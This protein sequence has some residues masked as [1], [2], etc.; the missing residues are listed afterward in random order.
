MSS[1]YDLSRNLSPRT[2]N[3]NAMRS[4]KQIEASRINGAKSKGPITPQGKAISSR[5]GIREGLLART[6]VLA[7]ESEERFLALL[8]GYVQEFQPVIASEASLVEALTVAKWRQFRVWGVQKTGVDRDMAIQD[9]DFGPASVCAGFALRG[10]PDSICAPDLLHRYEVIY[11]RQ[12]A[13]LYTRLSDLKSKNKSTPRTPYIPTFPS[14]QTFRDTEST[15]PRSLEPRKSPCKSEPRNRLKTNPLKY[16]KHEN[17]PRTQGNPRANVGRPIVFCRLPCRQVHSAEEHRRLPCRQVH[18][19]G[20]LRHLPQSQFDRAMPP[21]HPDTMLTFD[22][23]PEDRRS[24]PRPKPSIPNPAQ[25]AEQSLSFKPDQRQRDL[26]LSTAKQGILN[27]SRQWGKSTVA[28]IKAVHRA[29]FSPDSLVIVASPT[30]RQSAEFLLKARR[31]MQRLRIPLRGDGHHRASLRFPN[32]SRIVGLPGKEDTIRG[33]SEVSLLII[34]EAARVSDE[35][36]KALRP[37]LTVAN[38]DVWL[39]STPWGKQGFFHA[40]WEYGG[41]AWARFK[42]PATECSRI[43]PERLELERGQLGDAWFRQEYL[44]EFVATKAQMFDPDLVNAAINESDVWSLSNR[45][46]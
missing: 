20:E 14:G 43:A 27:C 37:M 5:N 31:F 46:A 41:E 17:N 33:Y 26:L 16:E 23:H 7:E 11:E 19:A 13:R 15:R 34:D 42:V 35:M 32:G 3:N 36:Y 6:V 25:F 29:H 1:Q 9:P 38:G 21:N 44:C 22:E 24:H 2:Y 8:E 30:E 39:L 10:S 12:F 18:S 28:A 40:N 45:H 4:P